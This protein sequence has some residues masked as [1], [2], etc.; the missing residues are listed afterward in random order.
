MNWINFILRDL[1]MDLF[2]YSIVYYDF[3]KIKQKLQIVEG[4]WR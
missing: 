4:S 2:N 3:I 1:L